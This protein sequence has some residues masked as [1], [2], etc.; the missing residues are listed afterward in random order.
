MRT[1]NK[2][3]EKKL[4]TPFI[5]QTW[6]GR[7]EKKN[8][9]KLNKFSSPTINVYNV[10]NVWMSLYFEEKMKQKKIFVFCPFR[11]KKDFCQIISHVHKCT[12]LK[13]SYGISYIETAPSFSYTKR[14]KKGRKKKMKKESVMFLIILDCI[15]WHRFWTGISLYLKRLAYFVTFSFFFHLFSSNFFHLP[16]KKP[17]AMPHLHQNNLFNETNRMLTLEYL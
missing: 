1:T 8:T 6:N 12:A 5:R 2:K 16:S 11:P 3:E 14:E 10:Y 9:H 13:I 7:E 4:T 15:L 17:N